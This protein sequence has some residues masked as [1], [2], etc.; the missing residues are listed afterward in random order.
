M[1]RTRLC[2]ECS[3]IRQVTNNYEIHYKRGPFYEN[4][5]YGMVRAELGPRVALA[6]K[7]AGVFSPAL[8]DVLPHP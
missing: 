8:D 3:L 4:R 2:S 7:Q 5:L 1:S 6:L